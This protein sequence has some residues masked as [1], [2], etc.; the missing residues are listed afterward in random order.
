MDATDDLGA[1]D[2]ERPLT[3]GRG[4]VIRRRTRAAPGLVSRPTRR[5]PFREELIAYEIGEGAG[6]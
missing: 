5:H 3:L 2:T 1:P 4:D 6:A